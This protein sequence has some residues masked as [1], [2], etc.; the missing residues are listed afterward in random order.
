MESKEIYNKLAKVIEI[1]E[2]PESSDEIYWCVGELESIMKG[3]K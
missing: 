3:V 2:S 1:L